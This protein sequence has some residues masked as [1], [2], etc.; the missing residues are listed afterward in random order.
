MVVAKPRNVAL[1]KAAFEDDFFG[2][3]YFVADRDAEQQRKRLEVQPF[4][5]FTRFRFEVVH[6]AFGGDVGQA[7]AERNHRFVGTDFGP[8]GAFGTGYGLELGDR[9]LFTFGAQRR[10]GVGCEPGGD[11]D[12][13]PLQRRAVRFLGEQ[14]FVMG[15]FER[16][17]PPRWMSR[18]LREGLFA[19]AVFFKFFLDFRVGARVIDTC[20]RFPERHAEGGLRGGRHDRE[21]RG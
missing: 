8:T 2:Q 19:V 12:A 21:Q 16:G 11:V 7:F 4:E 14:A 20:A 9:A 18:R 5:R 15:Q 13:N 1:Q 3:G 10:L 6:L 17:H